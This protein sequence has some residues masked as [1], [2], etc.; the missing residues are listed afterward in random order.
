MVRHCTFCEDLSGLL[1]GNTL[2]LLEDPA[3]S[4]GNGLDSVEAAIDDQLDVA[5]GEARHTLE[6]RI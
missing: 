2:Y 5:L 6:Q 4:I 3:R 1:L